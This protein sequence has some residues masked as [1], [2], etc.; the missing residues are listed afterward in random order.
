M[1]LF[2]PT[3]KPRNILLRPRAEFVTVIEGGIGLDT[4]KPFHDFSVQGCEF[5]WFHLGNRSMSKEFWYGASAAA[6][7]VDLL[8][9][10]IAYG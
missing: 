6:D 2:G 5:F 8:N 10:A 9:A 4:F 1:A 7:L 3:Q